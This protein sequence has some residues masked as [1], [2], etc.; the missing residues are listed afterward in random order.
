MTTYSHDYTLPAV[1]CDLLYS[2]Q[3]LLANDCHAAASDRI[4]A[5]LQHLR[6][7]LNQDNMIPDNDVYPGWIRGDEVERGGEE[8]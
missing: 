5:A 2:A 8:A 7:Y 1:A 4:G 6:Q 3:R